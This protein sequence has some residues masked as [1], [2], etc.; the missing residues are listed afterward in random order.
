MEYEL[1]VRMRVRSPNSAYR[2]AKQFESVFEFGTVREAITE[3]LRLL[4]EP[5]LINVLASAAS[6]R[7]ILQ[8][9]PQVPDP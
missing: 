5:H 3:G 9:E 6:R 7:T 8:P 1:I 2:V 4:E